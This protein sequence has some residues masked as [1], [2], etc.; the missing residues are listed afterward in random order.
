VNFK[1]S[2]KAKQEII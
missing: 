1:E 2:R